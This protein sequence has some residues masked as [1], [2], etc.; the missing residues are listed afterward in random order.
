MRLSKFK[1][2][3]VLAQ[4]FLASLGIALVFVG[5]FKKTFLDGAAMMLD[6]RPVI[7]MTLRHRRLD[8]FWFVLL[9]ELMHVKL[10]L[11]EADDFID[12]DFDDSTRR[13]S[14]QE[15]EADDGA[16]DALIPK[17]VWQGAPVAKTRLKADALALASQLGIH[18]AI[19]AGR[20]GHEAK[21]WRLLSGLSRTPI[22]DLGEGVVHCRNKV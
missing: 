5:H 9:H 4:E 1:R 15:L 18:P 19:V 3:P 11:Q 2:S 16:S 10:H 21:D 7:G 20:V 13:Q 22:D 17:E 6:G 14:T 8:N 12:D